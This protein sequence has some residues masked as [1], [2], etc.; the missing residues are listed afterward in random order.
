MHEGRARRRLTFVKAKLL[1]GDGWQDVQ[2]G[3][4]S[5]TGLLVRLAEPPPIGETVEIRHRG[6]CLVG[7]V[8]WAARSRM[9]IASNEPIDV[10]ALLADSGIGSRPRSEALYDMPSPSFWKLLKGRWKPD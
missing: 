7:K 10:D 9:G 4:V 1:K 3:N 2:I 6:C 5:S 8:I